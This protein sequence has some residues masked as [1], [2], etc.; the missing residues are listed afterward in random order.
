MKTVML[1][2]NV[3]KLLGFAPSKA[4]VEAEA[5]EIENLQAEVNELTAKAQVI[6]KKIK[7]LKK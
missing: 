6:M 2:A 3:A 5:S 4:K 7:K 1:P